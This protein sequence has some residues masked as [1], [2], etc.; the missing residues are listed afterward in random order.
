MRTLT[1]TDLLALWET[2]RTMHPLDQG[3]LAVEAGFPESSGTIVDW[4]V[5]WRNRALVELRSRLFGSPLRGWSACPECEEKLEFS[6]DSRSLTSAAAEP[7]RDAVE[8]RGMRFRVATSRDLAAV[9]QEAD[10]S[11]ATKRLL[12]QLCSGPDP[13]PDAND[14]ASPSPELDEPALIELGEKLA[15]ADPLAEIRLSFD[16][17]EC[18]AHFDETLDLPGFLWAELEA[19]AKRLLFDVH[20]LASAYGWSESEI[21]GLSPARRELYLEMVSV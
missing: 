6:L 15:A 11:T 16:C 9:A 19:E 18:G 21:L 17:P 14:I 2:G 1:Q 5:G 8:F 4:P 20:R 12:R 10:D 3:V 7:S 13:D